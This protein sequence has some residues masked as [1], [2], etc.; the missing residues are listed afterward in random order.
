MDQRVNTPLPE[1]SPEHE[2]PQSGPGMLRHALERIMAASQKGQIT[3]LY[4]PLHSYIVRALQEAPSR[5]E[6]FVAQVANLRIWG[7]GTDGGGIYEECV[8]P[9][10]G[11]A[12]S[13]ACLMALIEEARKI[14]VTPATRTSTVLNDRYAETVIGDQAHQYDALEVHGVRDLDEAGT[15]FL[16]HYGC[17]CG[18]KWVDEWSC[19]CNDRCPSC[20]KEIEPSESEDL[21]TTT[22]RAGTNCEVD[23]ENPQFFSVYAHRKE[24][25][26]VCVGDCATAELAMRYASELSATYGWPLGDCAA[27]RLAQES[28]CS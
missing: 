14:A 19:Q 26:V 10:E 1:S 12:D 13:H 28:T 27:A 2:A 16:N 3:G 17:P 24:G 11:E 25:G 4:G 9:A 7:Y 23:D 8:E 20:N 18:T 6:Q 5:A 15:L 21:S 22:A